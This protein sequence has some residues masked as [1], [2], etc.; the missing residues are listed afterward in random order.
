MVNGF[1]DDDDAH[2][3][4]DDDFS[5]CTNMADIGRLR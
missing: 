5:F 2:D 3:D 4:D 1:D